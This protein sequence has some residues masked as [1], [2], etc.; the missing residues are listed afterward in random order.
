M[1]QE[2]SDAVGA[3]WTDSISLLKGWR[4]AEGIER[5]KRC[6]EMERWMDEDMSE[7]RREATGLGE[8]QR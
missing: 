3:G 2:D 8:K 1:G 4:E 6:E 7:R 5:Y